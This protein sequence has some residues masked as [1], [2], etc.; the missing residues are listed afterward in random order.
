MDF[1]NKII[2]LL[3]S[4]EDP[5]SIHT[6]L[7]GLGLP[8]NERSHL[9]S[10]LRNMSRKGQVVK[11]GNKFWIPDGKTVTRELKR[12]KHVRVQGKLAI[13]SKGFGFVKI[14]QEGLSRD[15]MIYEEDL[16]GAKH[17]DRVLVDWKG[18][19]RGRTLG[20]VVEV[21]DFGKKHLLGSFEMEYSRLVFQPF[22]LHEASIPVS[23]EH[24]AGIQPGTVAVYV[25]NDKGGWSFEKTLGR[26]DDPAI[27]EE[28]V[29]AKHGIPTQFPE[30]VVQ[31]AESMGSSPQDEAISREDFSALNV[32][33]VDG[34][35]AR[36]FDDAIHVIS[37]EYGYE[38]GVHIADVAHYVRRGS[39]CDKHAQFLGNSTYLPHKAFPM[40]PR[41]L[42]ENL[43]SL[44]PHVERLT[45]SVVMQLDR[46]G[47]LM[48]FRITKGKIVS[49]H[50]LTYSQVY[51]MGIEKDVATRKAF[52][53]V[54]EDI[55]ICLKLAELLHQQRM[56]LGGLNLQTSEPRM[57]LKED[58]TLLKT[59]AESG[60]PANRMIEMFM[61][62]A[63]Q[64]VATYMASKNK[65]IP[66][67]I[68]EPPDQDK[69]AQF[70]ESL[71]ASGIAV[72]MDMDLDTGH[73]LNRILDEIQARASNENL[74]VWRTLLLRSLKRAEYHT[75][76][77][78]H[79]GLGLNYYCHFTSP[80]R[81]YADLIVHQLL[82]D[83]LERDVTDPGSEEERV[84]DSARAMV[85][86]SKSVLTDI[87]Q[88][89]SERE[90]GS[91]LAEKDFFK[92]KVLRYLQPRLGEEFEGV[93][94]DARRF[95]LVVELKD[96]FTE[97]VVSIEKLNGDFRLRG[98][99]LVSQRSGKTFRVGDPVAVIL[100]RIDLQ[101][102]EMDL[103][104]KMA[105][106]FQG[107]MNS[108]KGGRTRMRLK[109]RSAPS[110]YRKK[111]KRRS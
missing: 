83:M 75:E 79:F 57:T 94:V 101:L 93:I 108:S 81:R 72:P 30:K 60:T 89:L 23:P 106:A 24:A 10:Q 87:C 76:N 103:G 4:K 85:S 73:F 97:G 84:D 13:T 43:C 22:S 32:F 34:A 91:D 51:K 95:G 66:Y 88:H 48:D 47:N 7:K 20:R 6:L 31:E 86:H 80:I 78:G 35:D 58:H 105:S 17:G 74:F 40:L 26:L 65:P 27:D 45:C 69:V 59:W 33:T 56:E 82:S 67:R 1:E 77:K 55:D 25:R 98:Y 92:M 63:N 2:Q 11:K 90:R 29:L 96:L 12:K 15:W 16:N 14:A 111:R 109:S 104:L 99:S 68:H 71:S 3:R 5:V 62:L 19:S 49:K 9:R 42:S 46:E 54:V 64:V 28:L 41:V 53:T 18:V 102:L 21:V 61:C 37:T 44:N 8:K 52:S 36:D 38:L 110:V 107:R 39:A 70:L 100:E 50:R